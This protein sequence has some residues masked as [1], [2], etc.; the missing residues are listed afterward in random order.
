MSR[1][2]KI[3]ELVRLISS[4][5]LSTDPGALVSLACTCRNLEVPALSSLWET[6]CSFVTLIRLLPVTDEQV[7]D[8]V[9]HPFH[10]SLLLQIT[11][12]DALGNPWYRFRRYA[13]WMCQLTLTKGNPR[14]ADIPANRLLIGSTNGLL[15]P[16][17]CQLYCH[18]T[19]PILPLIP[20][21]LSPRLT[22][23]TL[24]NYKYIARPDLGPILQVL[25]AQFLQELFLNFGP[26]A[27]KD[28]ADEVSQM[29][30]QCGN[31]LRRLHVP[32]PLGKA[33][34]H[35]LLSLTDL[36]I[37][38]NV[39]SVPPITQPPSAISP[40]LRALTLDSKEAQKWIPWLTQRKKG[41]RSADDRSLE[42]PRLQTTLTHLG[43]LES[44]SVSAAFISPLLLFPNLVILDVKSN[45]WQ[46]LDC[47]FSLTNQD[48]ADLSSALPRLELLDLGPPCA[49]NAARTTV[50][51][52]APCLSTANFYGL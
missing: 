24:L 46:G 13:S 25:L 3:D 8:E 19:E 37:W 21:F 35:H 41:V 2:F 12:H 23:L 47:T 51:A 44:V 30:Q 20:L 18:I 17:L 40:S 42:H 26:E 9:S 28:Y 5:L 22:H 29:I 1:V 10:L 11:Q 49:A 32:M 16:N 4:H 7:R 50:S 27:M 34:V 43:F 38:E 14:V 45:C 15:C 6:Q 39:R 48:V 36:Q 31:S 33:A 52:S